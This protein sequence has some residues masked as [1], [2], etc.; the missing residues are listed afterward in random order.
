MILWPKTEILNRLGVIVNWKRLSPILHPL[1]WRR[2][3][4]NEV[5]SL[6][7]L[8]KYHVNLAQSQEP[9]RGFSVLCSHGAKADSPGAR[10]TLSSDAWVESETFVKRWG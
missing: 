1:P 8:Y 2:R 10:R 6:A 4:C 5:P 3:C 7:I 9:E